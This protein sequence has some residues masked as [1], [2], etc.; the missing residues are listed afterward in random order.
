MRAGDKSRYYAGRLSKMLCK[1]MIQIM[2]NKEY[3]DIPCGQCLPCRINKGRKWTA[4]LLLE[5]QLHDES[6]FVTLSFRESKLP[7][8]DNLDKTLVQKYIR[9]LRDAGIPFRYFAVG[10]YGGKKGRSHYHIAMFGVDMWKIF[11]TDKCLKQKNGYATHDD[12]YWKKGRV[13]I[14]DLNNKTASYICGYTTK[15]LTKE[16]A[17]VV[18]GRTP[19]F[20][21]QSSRPPLGSRYIVEACHQ[22]LAA[23]RYH[24][25]PELEA[26]RLFENGSIRINQRIWPLDRQML[27]TVYKTLCPSGESSAQ[28][29]TRQVLKTKMQIWTGASERNRTRATDVSDRTQRKID[30]IEVNREF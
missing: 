22:V 8:G 28:K 29:I 3:M 30:R 6:I 13:H 17:K 2:S 19:E 9:K 7:P 24:D 11:G 16:H 26:V 12:H 5:Q 21:I 14:G 1:T 10:E 25:N 27:K 18:A 20:T 4:R 23:A 15:K